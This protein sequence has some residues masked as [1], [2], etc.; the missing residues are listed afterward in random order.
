MTSQCR[1]PV[2][3]QNKT[4][5]PGLMPSIQSIGYPLGQHNSAFGEVVLYIPT[6]FPIVV[7]H[8]TAYAKTVHSQRFLH[9]MCCL[10]AYTARIA[11]VHMDIV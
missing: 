11:S 10:Y 1:L 6:S 4:L 8:S 9:Q 3:E 5:L 2:Y 7:S